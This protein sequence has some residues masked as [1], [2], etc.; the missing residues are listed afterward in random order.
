MKWL[1]LILQLAL[2]R[3]NWLESRS[4]MEAGQAVAE[5]SKRVAIISAGMMF[6]LLFF[7]AAILVAVIELGLQIDRG[8]GLHY[9]GLM[10]SATIFF[11]LGLALAATGLLLGKRAPAKAAPPPDRLG[12]LVEECISVFLAQLGAR[13]SREK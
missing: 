1:S 10:I 6:A 11:A 7:V 8:A 2:F 3:K 12:D 9:S 5:K 13:S 4:M